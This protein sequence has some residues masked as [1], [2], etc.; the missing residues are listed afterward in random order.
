MAELTELKQA[1]ALLAC[2]MATGDVLSGCNKTSA[3]PAPTV[4]PEP[5]TPAAAN[6]VEALRR[7]AAVVSEWQRRDP[8]QTASLLREHGIFACDETTTAC[9]AAK[10]SF[11]HPAPAPTQAEIEAEQQRANAARE[12]AAAAAVAAAN[13]PAVP[14]PT[15]HP[16]VRHPNDERVPVA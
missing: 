15:R 9:I 13:Q 2:A 4:T 1:V 16:A 5:T 11:D 8:A 10:Q 3:Q 6:D 14:I 12:A 7:A